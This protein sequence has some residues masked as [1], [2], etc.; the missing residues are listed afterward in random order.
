[1]RS[2]LVTGGGSGIGAAVAKSLSAAGYGVVCVGRRLERVE[3]IAA[4]ISDAGGR[5]LA[6][7]VDVRSPDQVDRAVA[8]TVAE[9]GRLD[10]LVNNAGVF[11]KDELVALSDD[12]WLDTIGANLNGA[13]Y[14]ARAAARQMLS[15]EPRHGARGQVINVNSGAGL[16]GY[17]TGAAYSASKFGL[18]GLSD[19][20]RQELSERLIKVTD[21]VVAAMV[22]SELSNRRQVVRLPASV[23]GTLVTALAAVEGAGVVT[24]LDLGQLPAE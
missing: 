4:E 2:A 10:L 18:L 22:Q 13:F 15:Q 12:D 9:F 24:R 21:L 7:A 1:M 8:D 20:M 16:R 14:C 11:R 5:A 6:R 19:T 23:V 17:P 3:E